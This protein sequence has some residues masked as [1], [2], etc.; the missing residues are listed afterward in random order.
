[1]A[2]GGCDEPSTYLSEHDRGVMST[3]DDSRDPGQ[4]G[5]RLGPLSVRG[6]DTSPRRAPLSMRRLHALGIS[7]VGGGIPIALLVGGW[8]WLGLGLM[9]I[10]ILGMAAAHDGGWTR[11]RHRPVRSA[12]KRSRARRR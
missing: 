12:P 4:D 9:V 8:A 5:R 10:V 1:M 6:G 2:R 11:R 3:D 7:L